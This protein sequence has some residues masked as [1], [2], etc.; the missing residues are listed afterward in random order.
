MDATLRD[1]RADA[2]LVR[3]E[4]RALARAAVVVTPHAGV[5]QAMAQYAPQA[6]LQRIDWAL[7]QVKTTH[8][9]R[10]EPPLVVFAASALAR[11]GARELAAALQGWPCR[12][13][14][15]G[16]PSDDARLW[17][18]I[19]HI[20]HMNW[21]GDWLAGASVVVLP[22]HVEHAPRALL[23]AVAGGVP[24][25]ASTACGL[26]GVPGVHEV[27]PGDIDALRT[28]LRQAARLT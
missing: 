23:R 13:R 20:Q 10:E 19:E 5:A 2:S 1:F 22:A 14:V 26:A 18:G 3:D 12:L 21:Q 7:P 9:K 8:G 27:A 15:L 28:A 25:V 24:V 4:T 17:Q 11:K 6:T 16:S